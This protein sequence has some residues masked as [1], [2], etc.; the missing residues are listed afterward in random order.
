M[1]HF[2]EQVL[3]QL[4]CTAELAIWGAFTWF[5]GWFATG[6]CVQRRLSIS[7]LSEIW[8]RLAAVNGF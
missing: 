4:Q 5:N 7:T 6:K 1:S 2:I 3:M 8:V